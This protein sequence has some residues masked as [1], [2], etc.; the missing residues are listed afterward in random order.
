[1][2]AGR[3]LHT[4]WLGNDNMHS[5]DWLRCWLQTLLLTLQEDEQQELSEVFKVRIGL[6]TTDR[7]QF[8]RM[9]NEIDAAMSDHGRQR[10]ETMRRHNIDIFAKRNFQPGSPPVQFTKN[11][12]RRALL[13]KST[14]AE[15]RA[16]CFRQFF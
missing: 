16:S 8:D 14:I 1:M 10:E 13:A 4:S 7:D 5:K 12:L 9:A 6:A 11:R 2:Q 3:V 15:R